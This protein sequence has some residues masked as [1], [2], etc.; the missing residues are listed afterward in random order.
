M[1]TQNQIIFVIYC[2]CW[3]CLFCLILS[4]A[5]FYVVYFAVHIVVRSSLFFCR[6]HRSVCCVSIWANENIHK[7]VQWLIES[8]QKSNEKK[9]QKLQKLK[10]TATSEPVERGILCV[11]WRKNCCIHVEKCND[12]ERFIFLF[13]GW[14]VCRT[15]K[16]MVVEK[17]WEIF[18]QGLFRF[19]K[20]CGRWK[21]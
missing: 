16:F 5:S 19:S 17:K 13:V 14:L 18:P 4:F 20:T 6:Q 12:S 21:L 3:L 7:T 1:H 11:F 2:H 15:L 9:T 10:H 8:D